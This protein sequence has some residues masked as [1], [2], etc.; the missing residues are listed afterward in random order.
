MMRLV[1]MHIADAVSDAKE[2]LRL[3]PDDDSVRKAVPKLIPFAA[4][5]GVDLRLPVMAA[6]TSHSPAEQHR[7]GPES[8]ATE[9][10]PG[11]IAWVLV[12]L[13]SFIGVIVFF[14]VM[15]R[16]VPTSNDGRVTKTKATLVWAG[17]IAGGIS[18]TAL[19]YWNY[20]RSPQ[21]SFWMAAKAAKQHDITTFERYADVDGITS[22]LI[23]E[24]MAQTTKNSSSPK[25]RWEQVGEALAKGF[26]GMIKPRMVES[27][28]E[29]IE[30]WIEK[31]EFENTNTAPE[32]QSP[33]MPLKDVYGK[34]AGEKDGFRGIQYVKKDGK[35]AYVGLGF[36]R[37]DYDKMLVLDLKM[38]DKGGY[39]QIAEISNFPD[40]IR[41]VN[42]LEVAR[43]KKLNAPTIEAMARA[44][45][46]QKISK[47][48][49]ATDAWGVGKVVAFSVDAMNTDL[50]EISGVRLAIKSGD[51]RLFAVNTIAPPTGLP[52]GKTMTVSW[53]QSVNALDKDSMELYTTPQEKLGVV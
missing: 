29:Q 5:L 14:R 50:K 13:L 30:R 26:V 48:G 35:I 37:Q 38:R 2:A 18:A 7:D 31:G 3:A 34:I 32:R 19:W 21:Y 20:T 46:I 16:G 47:K 27:A 49:K 9:A 15:R 10:H 36:Y 43:I 52:P 11:N 22:R 17:L 41:Q 8:S 44:L 53:Q 6:K 4:P 45:V 28:K 40:L 42:E 23:D 25:G 1:Q 51:G 39:W 12:G 24:I 33:T